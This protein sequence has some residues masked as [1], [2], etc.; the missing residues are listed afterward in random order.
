MWCISIARK[1]E[2]CLCAIKSV[3]A[4]LNVC[5]RR[6]R[7]AHTIL[8]QKSTLWGRMKCKHCDFLSPKCYKLFFELSINWERQRERGNEKFKKNAIQ[9]HVVVHING[10]YFLCCAIRLARFV[11]IMCPLRSVLFS[12]QLKLW[13]KKVYLTPN[14]ISF[15]EPD[16]SSQFNFEREKKTVRLPIVMWI[17][18]GKSKQWTKTKQAK[19]DKPS[20]DTDCPGWLSVSSF[21]SVSR[22]VKEFSQRIYCIVCAMLNERMQGAT[23]AHAIQFKNVMID[24]L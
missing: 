24:G 22:R 4:L 11:L 2:R 10:W 3:L 19:I 16:Q 23:N 14:E 12:V 5:L 7:K 21:S 8:M 18:I 6:L 13:R 1:R 9:F 17:I 20:V 15:A